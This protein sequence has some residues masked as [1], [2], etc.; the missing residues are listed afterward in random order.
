MTDRVDS[1]D[2]HE[3][4]LLNAMLV[5]VEKPARAG[6]MDAIDR[7]L[8]ILTLRRQYRD[9]YDGRTREWKGAKR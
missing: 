7:V 4:D 8:K 9:D 2:G 6:D 1:L 3:L 5:A